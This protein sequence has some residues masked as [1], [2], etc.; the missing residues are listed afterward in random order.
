[1]AWTWLAIAGGFEVV[2]AVLLKYT[3]GFTRPL[4]SIATLATMGVSFYCMSRA[5]QVLPMGTVY[6][7]WVGIGAA[8]TALWGMTVE[9]EP[10]TAARILC[11]ALILAGVAGLKASA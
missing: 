7:V 2:W 11:L 10:A 3:E 6:A 8:G 5:L 9:G 1:M 4:P